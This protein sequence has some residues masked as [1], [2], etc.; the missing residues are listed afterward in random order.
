MAHAR[1]VVLLRCYG[2]ADFLEQKKSHF[3]G[4]TLIFLKSYLIE[5]HTP[6]ILLV[7]A[8]E[9]CSDYNEALL[10]TGRKRRRRK[11]SSHIFLMTF[12]HSSHIFEYRSKKIYIARAEE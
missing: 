3:F 10:M 9:H 2:F 6:S 8:I 7:A 11:T 1:R 12:S 5:V 4:D